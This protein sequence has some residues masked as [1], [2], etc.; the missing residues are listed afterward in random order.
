MS[1]GYRSPTPYPT[2]LTKGGADMPVI[3]S[4][5]ASVVRPKSA[6][7]SVPP[8]SRITPNPFTLVT[9]AAV[10]FGAIF[11]PLAEGLTFVWIG[12]ALVEVEGELD[13]DGLKG[14]GGGGARPSQPEPTIT[15]AVTENKRTL[16][17]RNAFMGDSFTKNGVT[18]NSSHTGHNGV[19]H[20]LHRWGRTK[21]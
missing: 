3:C 14:G 20:Y 18:H 12:V 10:A 21:S 1:P 5:P 13:V 9:F 15:R 8:N 17:C 4:E 2:V 19:S 7:V 6:A 16:D 11:E